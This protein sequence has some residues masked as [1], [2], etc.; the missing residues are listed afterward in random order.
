MTLSTASGIP[1]PAVPIQITKRMLQS[2]APL[3]A[4]AVRLLAMLQD[5]NA[6]LRR[7]A[8]VAS[9]DIGI[10]AAI[11]RMANSPVLGMR[12]RV[13]SIG[14]ALTLIGT[15]QARLIVL[16]C[17]VARA[18]QKELPL[19]GL[20]AG[21][22]MRHSELVASLTMGIARQL[23]YAAVGVAYSAGLLHDIG[24]VILNGMALQAGIEDP[25]Y[26][27]FSR[28]IQGPDP[29][30]LSLERQCFGSDHPSAGRD[31]AVH[32]ALPP[33]IIE[34]IERHHGTVDGGEPDLPA[35]LALANTVAGEV[36]PAYPR[37]RRAPLPE[38][39]AVPVEPLI[40]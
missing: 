35:F 12:G 32:W 1:T 34:A 16:S 17:G 13:G 2:L 6:P 19:Y 5:P 11:L 15:E 29:D 33:E 9:Q 40:A 27:R 25:T 24:K 8:D 21:A 36:D 37:A 38:R 31:A 7:I 30:V 28:A 22:F 14:E 18:G 23:S 10:S 26:Q 4:T 39:P 3:P 20:E